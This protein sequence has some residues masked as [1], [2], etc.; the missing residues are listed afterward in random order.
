MTTP[1]QRLFTQEY[2]L[3]DKVGVIRSQ[4][5]WF[6]G[7]VEG[8]ITQISDEE[9]IV[10][11]EKSGYQHQ[12]NHPRDIYLIKNIIEQPQLQGWTG[13]QPSEL[14]IP[15]LPINKEDDAMVDK[16]VARAK[17]P[18]L[19]NSQQTYYL[20]AWET[21]GSYG[22]FNDLVGIYSSLIDADAAFIDCV[23][24]RN[25]FDQSSYVI[26]RGEIF[27]PETQ[28]LVRAWSLDH[29]ERIKD[30]DWELE[31]RLPVSNDYYSRQWFKINLCV[32]PEPRL[33]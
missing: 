13:L 15:I 1:R 5:G 32:S 10:T 29:P 9:V 18:T 26:D 11:E 21:Y 25:F 7:S 14:I 3:N 6:E 31:P 23:L 2:K 22:G 28:K 8:H 12:I 20:F 4:H 17:L 16:L 19:P 24:H 30:T 33:F 27:H